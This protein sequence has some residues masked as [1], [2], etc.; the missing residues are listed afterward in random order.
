MRFKGWKG[1]HRRRTGGGHQPEELVLDEENQ[2]RFF[3]AGA[4]VKDE[5]GWAWENN[6]IKMILENCGL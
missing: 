6:L 1:A 4:H 3:Q 2:P 5:L